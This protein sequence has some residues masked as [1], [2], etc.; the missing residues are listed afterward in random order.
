MT[1]AEPGVANCSRKA[2]TSTLSR[3]APPAAVPAPHA[4]CRV[5]WLSFTHPAPAAHARR[6]QR[7]PLTALAARQDVREVGKRSHAHS[8]DKR[9]AVSFVTTFD[10]GE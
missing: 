2:P 10:A 5:H 6:W 8:V 3:F 9:I 4:V 7:R 1:N